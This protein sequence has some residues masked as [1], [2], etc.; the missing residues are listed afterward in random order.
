MVKYNHQS[1]GNHSEFSCL[2]ST[3]WIYFSI[4]NNNFDTLYGILCNIISNI[5]FN[6]AV[7]CCPLLMSCLT[8]CDPMDFSLPN[9]SFHGDLLGKNT[10]PPPGD[11]TKPGIKLVSPALQVDYLPAEISGKPTLCEIKMFPPWNPWKSLFPFY[12][13]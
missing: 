7:L 8:L 5:H 6:F 4:H 2:V 12:L 3:I 1:N 10:C 11:P 9:S 13:M